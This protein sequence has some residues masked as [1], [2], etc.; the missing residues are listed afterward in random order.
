MNRFSPMHAL[1]VG[2]V[3]SFS[4]TV[5][6]AC[7][8]TPPNPCGTGQISCN[9]S[10]TDPNTDLYD[11]G[12][13]GV[14]CANN[15]VCECG[16]CQDVALNAGL[17]ASCYWTGDLF[18]VDTEQNVK[19]VATKVGSFPAGL[20]RYSDSG[21]LVLDGNDARLY[22]SSLPE[23]RQLDEN[24]A[25]GMQPTQVK[26]DGTYAYVTGSGEDVVDVFGPVTSATDG[27]LGLGLV[28]SVSTGASTD[29]FGLVVD[30]TSVYV[31]LYGGLEDPSQGQKIVKIDV[32]DPANP[33]IAA[34]YDL[35]GL[36]LKTS[37]GGTDLP[38]PAGLAM[39]NGAVYAALNNM[40][41]NYAFNGPGMLA[42]VDPASGTVSAI[43]LGGDVCLNAGSVTAVGDFLA[44]VC[45]GQATYNSD[46]SAITAS[47]K[48]GVVLVG[49]D[50]QVVA[51]W[52]ADCDPSS[53]VPCSPSLLGPIAA[54]GNHLYIGDTFSGRV[55]Q[56]DVVGNALQ[57]V[58]TW[59]TAAAFD[60]GTPGTC[61]A[62]VGPL[63][64]CPSDEKGRANVSDLLPLK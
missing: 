54:V 61:A 12:G 63:Q 52:S 6:S 38:R 64:V 60:G 55:F 30:G 29:P 21:L 51:S 59:R 20:A 9:T 45:S 15:Q 5:F 57:E 62:Q 26:T 4:A 58:H 33:A 44:V 14:R 13:C 3:L 34:T 28:G 49:A 32:S 22:E 56:L 39:R 24:N 19:G 48:S 42:K 40:D 8:G 53:T 47:A 36:D 43:D 11:C 10:C 16:S 35:S 18:P 31:S 23:L 46:Y 41:A 37:N 1:A 50:D 2:A 27:G 25:V 7:L 17:M